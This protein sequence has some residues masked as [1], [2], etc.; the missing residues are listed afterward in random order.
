[1]DENYLKI[2]VTASS[3]DFL[4]QIKKATLQNQLCLGGEELDLNEQQL[5]SILGER[6]YSGGSLPESVIEEIEGG[7]NQLSASFYFKLNP[8]SKAFKEI[9]EQ[10]LK[11]DKSAKLDYLPVEESNWLENWKKYYTPQ[12]VNKKIEV[13]PS[14]MEPSE[15]KQISIRIEPGQAFGTGTHETTLGCIETIAFLH[16]QGISPRNLLDFGCGSGVLAISAEKIFGGSKRITLLDIDEVVQGNCQVNLNLNHC[17]LDHYVFTSS[18][19]FLLKNQFGYDLIL[20]NVLY[21]VLIEN[22]TFFKSKLVPGGY[23]VVSGLLQEQ[24]Q[25]LKDY[26]Q[27]EQLAFIHRVQRGDWVSLTFKS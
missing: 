13:I 17:D 22:L 23:I 3:A 26:Y 1:M 19:E 16:G 7:Q 8:S 4:E 15:G 12:E 2:N 5:D 27:H 9:Q 20:A 21:P 11:I 10:I 18:K 14:W 24:E 25:D 6:S